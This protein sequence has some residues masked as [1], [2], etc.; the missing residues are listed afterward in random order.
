M[1]GGA[2]PQDAKQRGEPG[3][4]R[5]SVLPEL[6]QELLL[7]ERLPQERL[8]PVAVVAGPCRVH[9]Q[10]DLPQRGSQ[11]FLSKHATMD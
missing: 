6:L 2:R 4:Y 5:H 8:A 7:Q 11:H 9:A 3:D 10:A 1:Y